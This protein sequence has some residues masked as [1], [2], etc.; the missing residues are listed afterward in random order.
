M[1]HIGILRIKLSRPSQRSQEFY[2]PFIWI[3]LRVKMILKRQIH[4][5]CQSMASAT[6]SLLLQPLQGIFDVFVSQT[7]NQRI[8]HGNHH[9]VEDWC[10]TVEAGGATRTG[11]QV[12]KHAWGTEEAHCCQVG[13]AGVESFGSAFHGSDLQDGDDRVDRGYHDNGNI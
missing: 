6:P 10:E 13:S 2:S 1:V 12:D 11:T 9:R 7:V 3:L 4:Q 8:Q 5:K